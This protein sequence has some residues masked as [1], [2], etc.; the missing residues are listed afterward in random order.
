M[1]ELIQKIML[2]AYQVNKDTKHTIFLDFSGHVNWIEITIHLNGWMQDV[3][4]EKQ[5]RV[6]LDKKEAMEELQKT[7]KTLEELEE[8]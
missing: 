4:P 8:K 6:H 7:L 5:L 1:E 3:D 2:K